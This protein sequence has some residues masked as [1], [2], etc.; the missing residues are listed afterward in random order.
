[1]DFKGQV[2]VVTGAA[3]GIGFALAKR[4]IVEGA[5]LILLDLNKD[6]LE[7]AFGEYAEQVTLFAI[8]I[9]KQGEVKSAIEIAAK[10]CGRIDILV[11]CAG[12]TGITNVLSHEV[13][14]DNLQKVF[15]INFMASF[16]TA[17]AVLPHMMK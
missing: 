13:A 4:L 16:Y 7:K 5:K 11:N 1:M 10:K 6:A 17:H 15:E 8:D 3:S 12:I 9:T 2:A 14:T